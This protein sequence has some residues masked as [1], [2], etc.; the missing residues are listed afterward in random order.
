MSTFSFESLLAIDDNFFI[1][2][3]LGQSAISFID[4]V[5]CSSVVPV[6]SLVLFSVTD[7]VAPM[8]RPKHTIPD[9]D[10]IQPP[11]G[12][13]PSDTGFIRELIEETNRFA[14]YRFFPGDWVD[15]GLRSPGF[16]IPPVQLYS[17]SLSNTD[18]TISDPENETEVVFF[19]QYLG[20]VVILHPNNEFFD[21]VR[22]EK[23]FQVSGL[24][25]CQG[26]PLRFHL[27]QDDPNS[28]FIA[29]NGENGHIFLTIN[30]RADLK[31]KEHGIFLS[32]NLFNARGT[33]TTFLQDIW[34]AYQYSTVY[35]GV[36]YEDNAVDPEVHEN[37]VYQMRMFANR[38]PADWRPGTKMTV[39]DVVD[40][41]M[42]PYVHGFSRVSH[43]GQELLRRIKS[44]DYRAAS[45][46]VR[47]RCGR[48]FSTSDYHFLPSA[49]V[50]TKTGRCKFETYIN[51][52]C[53]SF[54]PELYDTLSR[55]FEI[56]IPRFEIVYAHFQELRFSGQEER[57]ASLG[58]NENEH[59]YRP[60]LKRSTLRGRKVYVVS[61][62]TDFL[63]R[64]ES[65]ED[66]FHTEGVSSEHIIMVGMYILE[67]VGGVEGGELEFCRHFLDFERSALHAC[68]AQNKHWMLDRIL[69]KDIRPLGNLSM[70]P[71]RLI[72]FPNSHL[73]K[74]S[75]I[76]RNQ[77]KTDLENAT[78]P[79][80]RVIYFLVVDPAREVISSAE[81]PR[82]QGTSMSHQEAKIHRCHLV[83]ERSLLEERPAC[84]SA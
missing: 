72:V 43:Q 36:I 58:S 35:E 70:T 27:R 66:G 2:F 16:S 71:G 52:I 14:G 9:Q 13:D 67:R 7:P 10:G 34:E 55:L 65:I 25:D 51:N 42:F 76:L 68:M 1:D 38:E 80:M 69:G 44:L 31:F 5:V 15:L 24:V 28:A 18:S 78:T 39:R 64:E 79:L 60:D 4:L 59:V 20:C 26:V 29:Y 21:I 74:F 40:P 57:T 47:D 6:R 17:T 75:S 53:R 81:V 46:A 8:P 22:A 41:A 84:Y 23:Q 45:E 50:I 73:H 3:L 32:D 49:V 82:Q 11:A 12:P 56:F 61:K 63:P 77:F 37:L 48:K 33:S 54:Y 30:L 62:V 83:A 19:Q